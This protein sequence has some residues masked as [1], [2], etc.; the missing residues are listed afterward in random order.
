MSRPLERYLGT[1]LGLVERDGWEYA[2][3]TNA[4][5]VAV[6]VPVTREGRIVLVEQYRVPVQARVLELPAGLVGDNEDADEPIAV[7]AQRELLEETGYRAGR[8]RRLLHCPSTAGLSDE[9]ITFF[10]AEDLRREGP[11]GGDASEDIEVHEVPL[12]A[13]DDWLGDRLE[14]GVLIDPKVYSALYWLDD[15]RR[16]EHLPGH[17][18]GD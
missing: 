10:L 8:L 7:A 5:A 16:L 17:R 4:R 1:Y 9:M 12:E 2:T 3:R 15:R 14:A 18:G 13:V 6:L 11:G